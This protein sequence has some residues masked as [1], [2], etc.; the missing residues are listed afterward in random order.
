M[1]LAQPREHGNLHHAGEGLRAS[2][3]VVIVLEQVEVEVERGCSLGLAPKEGSRSD[4]H[5]KHS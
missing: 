1:L 2:H 4:V 5:P 3:A